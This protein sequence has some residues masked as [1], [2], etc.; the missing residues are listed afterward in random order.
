MMIRPADQPRLHFFEHG[1]SAPKF[2]RDRCAYVCAGEQFRS[3]CVV[4]RPAAGREREDGDSYPVCVMGRLPARLATRVRLRHV[5]SLAFCRLAARC[6]G[7]FRPTR[8]VPGPPGVAIPRNAVIAGSDIGS[9]EIGVP[10]NPAG[11][12]PSPVRPITVAGLVANDLRGRDQRSRGGL[13][14]AEKRRRFGTGSSQK[15]GN[16]DRRKD[17]SHVSFSPRAN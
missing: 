4:S 12:G 2:Q 11:D 7:D 8:S 6:G 1:A 5:L 3:W 9:V 14:M 17:R 16:Q 13:T 10:I 15:A